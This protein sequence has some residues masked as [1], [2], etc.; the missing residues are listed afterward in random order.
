[1]RKRLK[2]LYIFINFR[3]L[4]KSWK[5][6]NLRIKRISLKKIVMVINTEV[7][8]KQQVLFAISVI[9]MFI[10]ILFLK[11]QF[12][13][14]T[15]F[16]V[17]I[18][19]LVFVPLNYFVGRLYDIRLNAGAIEVKNMWKSITYPAEDLVDIQPFKLLV[20]PSAYNP[21]IKLIFKNKKTVVTMVQ[22]PIRSYF[23][24]EGMAA[25]VKELRA[26]L[27]K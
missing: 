25:Y 5:E 8:F 1:M 21:Y 20:I 4:F 24:G 3:G 27:I 17:F 7:K 2:G 14:N 26:N 13:N 23:S 16:I 6:Y 9:F 18:F 19:V 11:F 15:I 10:S 12:S 22:R